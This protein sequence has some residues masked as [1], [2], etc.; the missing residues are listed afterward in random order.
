MKNKI[1]IIGLLSVLLYQ[2]CN[3]E[4]FDTPPIAAESTAGFYSNPANIETAAIACY[5]QLNAVRTIDLNY[6][7]GMGSI[8]S[9][10]CE[11]G[12]DGTPTDTPDLQDLDRM[13]HT[14]NSQLTIR[15]IWAYMFKGIY[16][17]NY[18]LT[19]FPQAAEDNPELVPETFEVRLAEIKFL[20]ALYYFLLARAYGGLPLF[21]EPP[22]V[23][24]FATVERSAIKEIFAQIEID[25]NE[26][27]PF[28]PLD[29]AKSEPGRAS[30]GAAQTLMA[31]TLLYE[32]SYAEN[33]PG[34]ARFGDMQERWDEALQFAEDVIAQVPTQY[35]LVGIDGDTYDTYWGPETDGYRFI[36]TLDGD[37]S[38]ESIF[39]IQTIVDAPG[40][41]IQQRGNALTQF[42]TA[43][44]YIDS[45]GESQQIGWG[46]N[47]PTEDLLNTY[48]PGDPRIHTSIAMEGDSISVQDASIDSVVWRPI[49]FSLSPTG[50]YC[51]KYEADYDEFYQPS[52]GDWAAGPVNVKVFRIADV[53]LIAAEAA[54]KDGD[55]T[56]ALEYVNKVRERA[57][58]CGGTGN[59]I[60]ADF[61]DAELDIQAI[62]DERRRE[63]AG[64]GHRFY[65]LV[66]WRIAEDKL[67]GVP[68][69]YGFTIQFESP[70]MIS[71]L[72][73]KQKLT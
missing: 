55:R 21:T 3:D 53:Y 4:F 22:T 39:E 42:T 37:N 70:K 10:D 58:M 63:L 44:L 24:E 8:A 13:Q 7:I 61:T 1:L 16:F 62:M 66:R 19:N 6:F 50:M 51:R 27:I 32:S 59:T 17:C 25:L 30:K 23:D 57:R 46:F 52:G 41:W 36:F 15:R 12:G 64:E 47:C 73:H 18:A 5:S 56:K 69:G 49:D 35:R 34:D 54:F 28:L 43:R 11:A 67:A 26:A 29:N 71:S 60:P 68:I 40:G 20:R 9:D 45:E 48:E 33:Y 14:P 65:D 72:Y 31:Y 2:G 38:E